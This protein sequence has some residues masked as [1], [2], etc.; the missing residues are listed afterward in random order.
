MY[1]GSAIF[2]D[3][4]GVVNKKLDGRYVLS[5]KEFLFMS[6]A[7][8]AISKLSEKFQ[9]III[10]T[11][12]QGI[13]KGLMTKGDLEKL[14]DKMKNEIVKK[15]GRIDAIYY[16]PDLATK[17][18]NCRKPGV[19][20]FEEAIKDFPKIDI[21]KSFMI[22]DSDSDIIAGKKFGLNTVKVDEKFK[23]IDWAKKFNK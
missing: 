11:N 19:K 20:M 14:H 5:F 9:Y 3:R 16:C 2:L 15:G 10:I 12:Q 21:T 22:G 7:L 1:N 4:D 6:G 23:L 18:C 13:G 8:S 17:K